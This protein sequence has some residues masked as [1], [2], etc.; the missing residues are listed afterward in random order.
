MPANVVDYSDP[1]VQR[2]NGIMFRKFRFDPIRTLPIRREYVDA[3][4]AIDGLRGLLCNDNL[5]LAMWEAL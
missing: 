5:A 3:P 2:W 4:R 1:R